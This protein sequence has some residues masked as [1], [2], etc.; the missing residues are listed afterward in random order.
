MKRHGRIVRDPDTT[1]EAM[2]I[3]KLRGEGRIDQAE[4]DKLF[5]ELSKVS[6]YK[7]R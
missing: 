4:Q 3:I 1:Q 7:F 6:G 2:S 5:A